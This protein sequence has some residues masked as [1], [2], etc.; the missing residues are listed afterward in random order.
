MRRLELTRHLLPLPTAKTFG[1]SEF[2]VDPIATA[3]REVETHFEAGRFNISGNRSAQIVADG[4][5]GLLADATRVLKVP[6]LQSLSH[7]FVTSAVISIHSRCIAIGREFLGQDEDFGTRRSTRI[8]SEKDATSP[9]VS[10][11]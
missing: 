10:R 4:V 9:S 2:S 7:H 3:I 5:A 11:I 6:L 1:F 8:T